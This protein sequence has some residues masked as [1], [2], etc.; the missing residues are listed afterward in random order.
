MLPGWVGPGILGAGAVGALGL[1]V[2]GLAKFGSSAVRLQRKI[3]TL[4]DLP[5][6]ATLTRTLIQLDTAQARIAGFPALLLRAKVALET[7]DAS[8]RRF[9]EAATTVSGVLGIARFLF[10]PPP[11]KN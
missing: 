10:T 2:A 6:N 11:A 7:L 1:S 4:S 8:R 5:I 3:E 9:T